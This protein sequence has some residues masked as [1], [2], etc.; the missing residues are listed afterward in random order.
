MT[1]LAKNKSLRLSWLKKKKEE[2]GSNHH[3][4]K[5]IDYLN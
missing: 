5:I 2:Q 3:H 1:E 4:R